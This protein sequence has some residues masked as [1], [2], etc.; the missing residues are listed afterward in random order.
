MIAGGFCYKYSQIDLVSI[1]NSL[2]VSRLLLPI[3]LNFHHVSQQTRSSTFSMSFF[4]KTICFLFVATVLLAAV[5]GKRKCKARYGRGAKLLFDGCQKI[6][7]G[8]RSSPKLFWKTSNGT[9][10]TY[11]KINMSPG[12]YFAFGWGWTGMV[13][14]VV[15]VAYFVDGQPKFA[16]YRL[17]GR[18]SEAVE[19]DGAEE[20]ARGKPKFVKLLF[21]HSTTYEGRSLIP[22]DFATFIWASGKTETSTSLPFLFYHGSTKDIQRI[23]L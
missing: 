14:S 3:A 20:D 17:N 6:T 9:I 12:D 2:S 8:D 1:L 10:T 16:P 21:N 22:G 7:K 4:S 15:R 13:G 5:E 19:P 23:V 11:L 18:Y